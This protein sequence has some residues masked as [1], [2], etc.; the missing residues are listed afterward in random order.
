[1]LQSEC[2]YLAVTQYP[3]DTSYSTVDIAKMNSSHVDITFEQLLIYLA[4]LQRMLVSV[5]A[6]FKSCID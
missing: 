4:Q 3:C 5:T 1:M 6:I 2:V